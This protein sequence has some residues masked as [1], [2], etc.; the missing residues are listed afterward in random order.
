MGT[1]SGR[2]CD[3][4]LKLINLLWIKRKMKDLFLSAVTIRHVLLFNPYLIQFVGGGLHSSA[5]KKSF[6]HAYASVRLKY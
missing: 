5:G 4:I 6:F 2:L 3:A 1:P